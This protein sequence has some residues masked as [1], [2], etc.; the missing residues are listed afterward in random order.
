MLRHDRLYF[1]GAHILI[2][3]ANVFAWLYQ[4]HIYG[5][6][7]TASIAAAAI[8]HNEKV[9]RRRAT[10]DLIMKREVDAQLT[11]S[12]EIVSGLNADKLQELA[13]KLKS[14]VYDGVDDP[15]EDDLEQIKAIY[16][17]LNWYEFVSTGIR[18]GALDYK[19]FWR[20]YCT[21]TIGDWEHIKPFVIQYRNDR[22][23][24]TYFKEFCWL[25]SNFK[26]YPLKR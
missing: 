25:A 16:H 26:K 14:S 13:I 3:A 1:W 12:Q 6:V 22:Q 10:I 5:F 20:N 19:I 9:S 23:K 4:N 11:K 2:V 24:N 7:L 18:E 15:N 17:V 8:M 21:L